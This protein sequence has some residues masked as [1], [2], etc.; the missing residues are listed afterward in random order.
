MPSAVDQEL[1]D[2]RLEIDG[3]ISESKESL[4]RSKSDVSFFFEESIIMVYCCEL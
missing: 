4:R 3:R 2:N 1:I